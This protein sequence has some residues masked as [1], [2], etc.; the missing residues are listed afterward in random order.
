MWLVHFNHNHDPKTG[1]FA[2]SSVVDKARKRAEQAAKTKT[3]VDNIVSTF[4]KK[5]RDLFGLK[6]DNEE[7]LSVEQ[8]E[9]VLKRVLLKHGNTPIAFFDMLDDGDTVNIAL[10]TRSGEEYRGKGY[11]SSVAKKGIDWYEKHKS[12]FENKP[13][14]WAPKKSNEASIKIAEKLGFEKDP[15]SEKEDSEWINYLKKYN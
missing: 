10:G 13:L 6:D 15:S 11:A 12:E 8:G 2:P 4:S 14:V 5:E 3:D 1:R 7:Y 9:Y